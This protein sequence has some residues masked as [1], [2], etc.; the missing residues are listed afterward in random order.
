ML[1]AS[2]LLPFL[3]AVA[4]IELTPGPNMGYLAVVAGQS[5][6]RAGLTVVAGVTLG[7]AI[8]L[9]ASVFGLAEA[10]LRWPWVYETLR[11]AGVAYML[12]LAVDTW[13]DA[14]DIQGPPPETRS[15]FLR[16]LINNL[17]NPKAAVF[18]VAVLPGFVRPEAGQPVLQVATLGSLHLV[19]SVII[20]LLIVL[21]ASR[22]STAMTTEGAVNRSVRRQRL[23]AV[24]L[25]AIAIWLAVSSAR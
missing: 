3:L 24:A 25:A 2:Q 21:M 19:V 18:Y 17:L 1:S 14:A 4:V 6:W 11:W 12:W 22:A 10:A 13:R 8:Y 23:F 20:H 16:G 5:G 15:L 9:V 7:L